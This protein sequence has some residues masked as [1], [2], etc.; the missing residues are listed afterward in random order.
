[1]LFNFKRLKKI[2][3]LIILLVVVLTVASF[4]DVIMQ[5]TNSV[6]NTVKKIVGIQQD[7]KETGKAFESVKRSVNGESD[8]NENLEKED[9]VWVITEDKVLEVDVEKAKSDEEI[10]EGL[11]YREHLCDNC[12]MVF[13]FEESVRSG[14]WMKN[15]LIPL[16]MIFIDKSGKIVDIKHNFEPCESEP[17]RSYVPNEFYKYVL[18]VNGGW[19]EQHDVKIGDEVKEI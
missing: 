16:D 1:M 3:G 2:G 4:R 10:R 15:C 5:K 6:V 18:E 17:C 9:T 13:Y 7:I 19:C 11:M 14:F 8:T 12:G